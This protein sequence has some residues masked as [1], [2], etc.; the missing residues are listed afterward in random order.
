MGVIEKRTTTNGL[1]YRV[2][3]RQNGN[4]TISKTFSKKSS[5]SAWMAKTEADIERD[6]YREDEELFGDILRRYIV[7]IGK[8]KP[9]GRSKSYSLNFL[10][11]QLG[12]LKLRELNSDVLYQWALDRSQSCASSTV[13]MDMSYIGVV[14]STAEEMWDCKPKFS[15]YK[16][17]MSTL[18][19][20]SVI[21]PS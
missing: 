4:K 9:F 20:L 11:E 10:R 17:A 5:A 15:D 6:L 16:K 2:K 19:K 3:I 14:L 18:K 8:I 1:S 13:M 7:E 12:H 21:T